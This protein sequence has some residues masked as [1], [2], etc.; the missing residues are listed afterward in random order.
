MHGHSDEDIATV[1]FQ[2][3]GDAEAL[4]EMFM[5]E[6][7]RVVQ[8]TLTNPAAIPAS[9]VT[10][11]GDLTDFRRTFTHQK[12]PGLVPTSSTFLNAFQSSHVEAMAS[13]GRS[14]PRY[15]DDPDDRYHI[16]E[17]EAYTLL[18]GN[19]LVVSTC[20]THVEGALSPHGPATRMTT[21]SLKPSISSAIK[22]PP[23]FPLEDE[24]EVPGVV[25][26]S[27][28]QAPSTSSAAE[29]NPVSPASTG[30]ADSHSENSS[31]HNQQC[32]SSVSSQ[33]NTSA[34]T[35]QISIQPL[36]A[37]N[38]LVTEGMVVTATAAALYDDVEGWPML[39]WGI[40]RSKR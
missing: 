12:T 20:S 39:I 25:P 1:I 13:M 11:D 33:A 10:D 37:D 6:A 8:F 16:S 38:R 32:T 3:Q 24:V 31:A 15:V 2:Q 14:P 40:Y 27:G 18:G 17:E 23:A 34:S 36:K 26:F 5:G 30:S 21:R 22:V 29:E 19:R 7:Q 9:P 4:A 28:H 35:V